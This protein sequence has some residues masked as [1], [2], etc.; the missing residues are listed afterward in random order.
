MLRLERPLWGHW[1]GASSTLRPSGKGGHVAPRASPG[2]VQTPAGGHH[3]PCW[4][5]RPTPLGQALRGGAVR[6]RGTPRCGSGGGTEGLWGGSGPL[7]PTGWLRGPGWGP[8]SGPH[9]P[10]LSHPPCV[11]GGRSLIASPPGAV[12]TRAG[13]G[14]PPRGEAGRGG[15]SLSAR[16]GLKG[17]QG[18]IRGLA[19]ACLQ[20]SL[21]QRR[22]L[23]MTTRPLLSA[24]EARRPAL[25]K[26]Q[27]AWRV[28]PQSEPP[29]TVSRA[30]GWASPTPPASSR[31]ARSGMQLPATKAPLC[32][33]QN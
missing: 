28:V 13:P 18:V 15:G 2:A 17:Q 1:G 14:C 29:T 25:H 19:H 10:T 27:G 8:V 6:A 5:P 9:F 20:P 21:W 7:L 4:R 30:V 32:S 33:K 31:I 12:G 23:T 26:Q 24:P 11:L 3:S 22:C 16:D